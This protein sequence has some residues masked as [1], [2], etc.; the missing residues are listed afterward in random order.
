[1]DEPRLAAV[2]VFDDRDQFIASLF[3]QEAAHPPTTPQAQ[4]AFRMR[5]APWLWN[6]A[7]GPI[8]PKSA[9]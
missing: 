1:M 5:W 6:R 8:L 3:L 7:P 4:A 2:K 9:A